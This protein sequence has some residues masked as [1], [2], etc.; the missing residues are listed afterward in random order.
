MPDADLEPSRGGG[1]IVAAGEDTRFYDDVGCLAA[2]AA[3][4]PERSKVYV[5]LAGDT[6][7][8]AAAAFYAR[9]AGARTPMGSG[10]VAFGTADEARAADRAGH[11]L[12]WNDVL[13]AKGEP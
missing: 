6:F 5:R 1:E 7:V 8:E 3:S 13:Q 10:L 4:R 9:P 2:D 12:G 11:V